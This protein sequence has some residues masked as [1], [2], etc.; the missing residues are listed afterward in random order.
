MKGLVEGA[1]W[2]LSSI[3]V[4]DLQ[5]ALA[6]KC[7]LR[8]GS[9]L[10]GE[11]GRG[12]DLVAVLKALCGCSSRPGITN[13]FWQP[14]AWT[15]R[16]WAFCSRCCRMPWIS[17]W[18]CMARCSRYLSMVADRRVILIRASGDGWG[19]FPVP[20]APECV[21]VSA[22]SAYWRAR[23]LILGQGFAHG[24]CLTQCAPVIA[25]GQL[26]VINS[27]W[28]PYGDVWPP[29]L[30]C[31][32]HHGAVNC[33]WVIGIFVARRNL[34]LASQLLVFMV[35]PSWPMCHTLS[36]QGALDSLCSRW[37]G[38]AGTAAFCLCF[39]LNSFAVVVD[40]QR[41]SYAAVI[42]DWQLPIVPLNFQH[43]FAL[44]HMRMC[45]AHCVLVAWQAAWGIDGV[46]VSMFD[47]GANAV[48]PSIGNGYRAWMGMDGMH[49][50]PSY[51]CRGV[52]DLEGV[53]ILHRCWWR[54]R[55]YTR[56]HS[57]SFPRRMLGVWSWE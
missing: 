18:D 42:R 15:R 9:S 51:R 1:S 53:L 7:F 46:K 31:T 20:P 43:T 38:G 54:P 4:R 35:W 26:V 16:L 8:C 49:W 52:V 6:I 55:V 27:G 5:H 30:V 39:R 11:C 14:S 2:Q 50:R 21:F 17:S 32:R 3:V 56:Y 40:V 19:S 36:N 29:G 13:V 34:R 47:H 25:Y 48:V 10:S 23:Q 12:K 28:F 41:L 22:A 37:W 44:M 24:S 57:A 45:L 33:N